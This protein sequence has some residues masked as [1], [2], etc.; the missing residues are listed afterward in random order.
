M[1]EVEGSL[2]GDSQQLDLT[3][4][5]Y[6]VMVGEEIIGQFSN[7]KLAGDSAHFRRGAVVLDTSMQPHRVVYRD[8]KWLENSE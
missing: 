6:R 8:R 3:K 7:A 5:R 4:Q 2:M 1:G